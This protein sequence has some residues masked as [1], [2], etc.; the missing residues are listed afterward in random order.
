MA[1]FWARVRQSHDFVG[2]P[3]ENWFTVFVPFQPWH[4]ARL[5]IE[6]QADLTGV[7]NVD[8]KVVFPSVDGPSWTF[9][10]AVEYCE[11]V[12]QAH[13]KISDPEGLLFSLSLEAFS[14]VD[15]ARLAPLCAAPNKQLSQPVC[16]PKEALK[17]E[18]KKSRR[19]VFSFLMLQN[20]GIQTIRTKSMDQ[21]CSEFREWFAGYLNQAHKMPG[22]RP[23]NWALISRDWMLFQVIAKLTQ[24]G[25][26]KTRNDVSAATSAFDAV[27]LAAVKTKLGGVT[28]YE[29]VK[30]IV[31]R[32]ANRG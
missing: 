6:R 19:D 5:G 22:R 16:V 3:F 12:F 20:A 11:A 25:L 24:H 18:I 8:V 27:A 13:A 15:G 9:E 1:E 23:K 2:Y 10:Q 31:K 4:V 26:T 32:R 17:L 30:S 21:C 29:T 28:S 14:V 7:G